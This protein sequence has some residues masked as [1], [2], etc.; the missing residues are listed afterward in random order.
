MCY[1]AHALDMCYKKTV[2]T[3]DNKS[4]R[5]TELCKNTLCLP[6]FTSFKSIKS[7]VKMFGV[8]VIFSQNSSVKKMS[9][10]IVFKGGAILFIKFHVWTVIH[11]IWS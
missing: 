9:I 11:F 10:R 2:K 5:K 1:P 7:V 4:D 8:N 6:F 3:F